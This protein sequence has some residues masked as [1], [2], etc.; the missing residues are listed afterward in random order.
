MAE[1]IIVVGK[2]GV[3][4]S[5]TAANITAA[6]AEAGRQVALIGYDPRWSATT[7]IRGSAALL[8]V[9]QWRSEE[10]VPRYALGYKGA[11][12]IEAGDFTIEGHTR[13]SAALLDLPLL[14]QH[15]ASYVIHDVA[16]EPGPYFSLPPACEGV[17]IVLVVTSGDMTSI[18]VVNEL[19]RWL[20]TV[21]SSNYRFGGVI[22]NN[23][24]GPL[25][26]SIISDYVSRTGTTI[27]ANIPHSVMVSVSDFYN[28]TLIEA[29]PSSHNAYTYRKLVRHIVD[30][31]VVPRPIPLDAGELGT[32]ATSW[33]EIISELETGV[34]RD[35]SNI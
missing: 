2:G 25:Y 26:E 6:L 15:G 22:I 33:G 27:V 8:P 14:I 28:Q 1:H 13:Q 29:A 18:N 31:L 34:V 20:N 24:K 7:T 3:G 23:L 21:S 30:S 19:F 9:P 5:T 16:W 10:V 12:C 17:P 11:L 35:G 32:W 4:K